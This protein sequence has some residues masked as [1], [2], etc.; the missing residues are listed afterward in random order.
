MPKRPSPEGIDDARIQ[1]I[2]AD[3]EHVQSILAVLARCQT[4]SEAH[5]QLA[6]L[7]EAAGQRLLQK[8]RLH[9]DRL[10]TPA[11]I[12]QSIADTYQ[13]AAAL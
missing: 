3:H 11:E 4:A 6:E 13:P 1:E 8:H 12:V 10:T 5:R 7:P 9:W 2:L